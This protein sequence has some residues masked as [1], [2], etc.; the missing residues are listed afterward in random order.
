MRVKTNSFGGN[1]FPGMKTR[2]DTR[3][4]CTRNKRTMSSEGVPFRRSCQQ[5]PAT[6][7]HVCCKEA[8]RVE[9]DIIGHGKL[10][11]SSQDSHAHGPTLKHQA[12]GVSKRSRTRSSQL[13]RTSSVHSVATVAASASGSPSKYL[14]LFVCGRRCQYPAS[15]A[16]SSAIAANGLGVLPSLGRRFGE[17]PSA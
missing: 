17:I 10:L 15:F 3:S 16:D 11:R 13:R 2:R 7:S 6:E 8:W 9:P 1:T 12:T 4:K 14:T 5:I